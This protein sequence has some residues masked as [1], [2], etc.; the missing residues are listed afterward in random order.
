MNK[1]YIVREEDDDTELEHHGVK[2]QKWGIR[3]YQNPDGS[4]TEEG[5]QR[6]GAS[7]DGRMSR[8][9]KKLF[10]KDRKQAVKDAKQ[11]RKELYK[12]S[13]MERLGKAGRHQVDVFIKDKYGDLTYKD[14]RSKD[15]ARNRRNVGLGIVGGMTAVTALTVAASVGL[16]KAAKKAFE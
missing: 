8:E 11:E 13:D 1:Y 7:E 2:G 16:V 15:H 6:Y 12:K 14:L 10:E 5:R 3:R 4:L 9:G